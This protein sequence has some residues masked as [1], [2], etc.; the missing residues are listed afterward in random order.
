MYTILILVVLGTA[1]YCPHSMLIDILQTFLFYCIE[2]KKS[3]FFKRLDNEKQPKL[4]YLPTIKIGNLTSH[5][6][7]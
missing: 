7:I 2:K 5:I 3:I 6:C 4:L 1:N